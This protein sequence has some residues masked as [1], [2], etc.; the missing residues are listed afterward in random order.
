MG[1]QAEYEFMNASRVRQAAVLGLV[2]SACTTTLGGESQVDASAPPVDSGV[3]SSVDAGTIEDAAPAMDAA[4]DASMDAF[5][6]DAGPVDLGA[7]V[8][9][10]VALPDSSVPDLGLGPGTLLYTM[11]FQGAT[12]PSALTRDE[13]AE[14]SLELVEAP[15]DATRQALR[16]LVRAGDS[17]HGEGYPRSEVTPQSST[18]VNRLAWNRLYRIVGAFMYPADAVFPTDGEYGIGILISGFQLHGDDSTSPVFGF[19][20]RNGRMQLDYRPLS[21]SFLDGMH[22]CGPAPRGERVDYE[23]LYRGATD[24]TGYIRLVLNGVVCF[25]ESGPSNRAANPSPGYMKYGIYDNFNTVETTS[26]TFL[27]LYLDDVAYYGF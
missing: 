23:I 27:E 3:D 11:S 2:L 16:V 15:W 19:Q 10:G 14:D 20:L 25:E 9:E 8:D 18:G 17:W 12:I 21:G 5:V 22:D 7:A 4:R 26:A 6:V 1:A 13:V 24:A